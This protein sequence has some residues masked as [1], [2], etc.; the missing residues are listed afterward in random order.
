VSLLDLEITVPDAQ[1]MLHYYW[2]RVKFVSPIGI[3]I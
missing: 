2:N 1:D 3:G